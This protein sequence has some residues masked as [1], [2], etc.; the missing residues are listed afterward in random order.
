MVRA[1]LNLFAQEAQSEMKASGTNDSCGY[2][3]GE[4]KE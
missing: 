3:P 2:L 4:Y 1:D